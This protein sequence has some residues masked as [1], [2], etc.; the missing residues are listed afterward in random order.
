MIKTF[1]ARTRYVETKKHKKY[2]TNQ[3]C[4]MF[5]RLV[6]YFWK[7]HFK[8]ISFKWK[9]QLR[10]VYLFSRVILQ[11]KLFS[12]HTSYKKQKTIKCQTSPTFSCFNERCLKHS[13]GPWTGYKA[14]RIPNHREHHGRGRLDPRFDFP[15][16]FLY[17]VKGRKKVRIKKLLGW[18]FFSRLTSMVHLVA[19]VDAK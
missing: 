15:P 9:R 8:T 11:R 10:T 4:L 19:G 5:N 16:D 7:S 17:L 13:T 14:V 2:K 3:W 6:K 12:N 1:C 18:Y